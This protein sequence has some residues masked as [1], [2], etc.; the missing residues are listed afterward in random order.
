MIAAV[1]TMLSEDWEQ[2]A[3]EVERDTG[4]DA[5]ALAFIFADP[6]RWTDIV[7]LT[8]RYQPTRTDYDFF[9]MQQYESWLLRRGSREGGRPDAA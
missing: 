6:P 8:V 9:T 2:L 7:G 1:R 4:G 5:L 3:G